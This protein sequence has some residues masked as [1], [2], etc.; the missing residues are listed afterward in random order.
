VTHPFDPSRLDRRTVLRGLGLGAAG[1]GLGSMGLLAAC[2]SG[3]DAAK[4]AATGSGST[5]SMAAASRRIPPYDP[6]KPYWEQGNFA[7][8]TTEETVTDLRIT[9]SLPSGLSGLFVRNG[10]NPLS[11]KADHWFLGDGMVH[12]VRLHGGKASW[13]RN[14]YVETADLKAQ[15][16]GPPVSPLP[17]KANNQ[18]NVALIHHAGRLLTLGEVGWPYR[19]DK[20]DLSTIGPWDFDGKLT[21]NTMTAHPKIDPKTG[22]MHFFGY[23]IVSPTLTYYSA[24]AHGRIDRAVPIELDGSR[25]VHDFAVT[26]REAIFWVGPVTFGPDPRNPYPTIPFHW[27]PTGRTRVGVMP[28][29]G[30]AADMRWVDIPQCFVFHGLNAH[31]DGDDIVLNLNKQEEAFGRKGDLLP[32]HLHEWRIG[33]AG[34]D[35]TFSQRQ[36]SD[37]SMDLPSHDRRHTGR[38]SRHGWFATTVGAAG[39]KAEYGFE[40]AG[41][42]HVDLK[43]GKEDVWDP[44]PDRRAG[45]GFFVPGG[46]AEGEGW[47]LTYVWD[48][49]TDRSSL[50]VFDAQ[51]MRKGPVAEVQLPTRVPFGFHGMW[52]DEADL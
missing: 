10:S 42:C 22:R 52:V 36:L 6:T 39:S 46:T 1:M 19:L 23:E 32:S 48:R 28:L 2:S 3:S 18:S 35:L 4:G 27:D 38:P 31:R 24:D 12:G 43:T 41:I 40:L 20:T 25:M 29:E 47:V 8:V 17:G 7:A 16:G 14:R 30:T 15:H 51:A 26:D 34:K 11:G 45:E 5:T 13:Y 21:G 49:T 50:A 37:R 44:G 9:G 33:T